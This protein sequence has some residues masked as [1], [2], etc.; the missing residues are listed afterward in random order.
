MR[1]FGTYTKNS[2]TLLYINRIAGIRDGKNP[3]PSPALTVQDHS[4]EFIFTSS[5][6]NYSSDEGFHLVSWESILV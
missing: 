3:T 4:L 6:L 2:I 1:G 5:V